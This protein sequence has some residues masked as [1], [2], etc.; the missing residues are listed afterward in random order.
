MKNDGA[1]VVTTLYSYILD[2]Q[3]ELT[4]TWWSCVAKLIQALM[5]DL[6]TSKN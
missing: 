4:L 6:V 3:R 5:G 1:G 2:A